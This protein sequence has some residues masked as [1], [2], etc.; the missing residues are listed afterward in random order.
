MKKHTLI[1]R[2]GLYCG[3]CNIYIAEHYDK[4][5]R[6]EMAHRH[7]CAEDK[8]CCNGCGALTDSCWGKGCK[9]V[10]CSLEKGYDYCFECDLCKNDSCDRFLSIYNRYLENKGI[11]LKYNLNRI[12]AGEIDELIDEMEGKY[13]YLKYPIRLAAADDI[14][15][16]W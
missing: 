4:V 11:D 3:V 16:L 8:V 15:F 9:I 10:E 12:K 7:N 5:L 1:G 14:D 13:S 6:K 2:C